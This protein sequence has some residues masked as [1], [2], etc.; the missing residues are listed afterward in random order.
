MTPEDSAFLPYLI[1]Y[2]AITVV[3]FTVAAYIVRGFCVWVA[4]GIREDAN[5]RP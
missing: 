5:R 4:R 2:G 1:I 3:G